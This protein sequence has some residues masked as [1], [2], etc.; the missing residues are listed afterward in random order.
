MFNEL[1]DSKI[2]STLCGII[3]FCGASFL[4]SGISYAPSSTLML[5]IASTLLNSEGLITV[6]GKLLNAVE[7]EPINPPRKMNTLATC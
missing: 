6:V 1:F 7:K 4:V 2:V 3:A 5:N